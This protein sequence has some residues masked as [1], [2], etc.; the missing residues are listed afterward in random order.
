MISPGDAESAK[1]VV[2]LDYGIDSYFGEC[3]DLILNDRGFVLRSRWKFPVGMQLA[4][5][6]CAHPLCAGEVPIREDV[7]GMVVSCER[8]SDCQCSFTITILFLDITE[9]AQEELSRVAER[10]EL[11]S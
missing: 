11:A 2:Y 9:P 8:I 5:R 7:I 3:G 6:V 10:L 1:I 4:V